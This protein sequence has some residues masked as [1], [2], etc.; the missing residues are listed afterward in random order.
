M[1]TAAVVVG[2]FWAGVAGTWSPCGFSM[3]ETLGPS[4]HDGGRRLTLAACAAFGLGAVAAGGAAFATL[5]VA[6]RAAGAPAVSLAVVVAAVGAAADAVGIRVRPQIRRQVPEPWRRTL[7]LPV[8]GLLYGVLLGLGFTTYVLC[9]GT[10]AIA[11]VVF[12]LGDPWLGVAAGLAFGIGR[13]L[14]IAVVAPLVPRPLGSRLLEAMASRPGSLRLTRLVVAASLAA[15]AVA[16][17]TA[18]GAARW[19]PAVDPSVA[20]ADVAWEVPGGHGVLLRA[21]QETALP[22]DDPALGG[23]YA[24]WHVGRTVTIA[25]RATLAP[26]RTFDIPAVDALAVSDAWLVFR[27]PRRDGGSRLGVVSLTGPPVY[28]YVASVAFPT[29][30]GRPSLDGSIIAYHRAARTSSAIVLVNARSGERWVVRAARTAQLLQPSLRGPYLL[31]VLVTNCVQE[32]RLG[33][34]GG[35]RDRILLRR[36]AAVL[37]DRGHEFGHTEQG[38]RATRCPNPT[39]PGTRILWTTALTSSTAYLSEFSPNRGAASAV[40]ERVAR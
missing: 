12:A 38:S 20:G 4:G 39:V 7:P 29:E 35:S 15:V 3:I 16:A 5:A 1:L 19:G 33:L 30:I 24:A 14:P 8:A 40:I 34:L 13:A 28:R 26:I 31:Y 37:R 6:G 36:P 9:V 11:V 10:W 2:A 25:D 23:A 21:G 17:G 27:Q 18:S 22:G 32:L